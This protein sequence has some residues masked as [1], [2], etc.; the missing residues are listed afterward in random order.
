MNDKLRNGMVA[1]DINCNKTITK[2]LLIFNQNFL[3]NSLKVKEK[4]VSI[5]TLYLVNSPLIF[6]PKQKFLV[7]NSLIAALLFLQIR[8]ISDNWRLIMLT[9]YFKTILKITLKKLWDHFILNA[10]QIIFYFYIAK[11]AIKSDISYLRIKV[12]NYCFSFNNNCY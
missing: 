3:D 4:A 9:D 11:I 1:I 5:Y 10:P 6:F 7:F 2:S 12:Q 8:E